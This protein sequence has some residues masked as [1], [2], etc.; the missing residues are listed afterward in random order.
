MSRVTHN[1]N[2]LE[3]RERVL[4]GLNEVRTLLQE[5]K[6]E[7]AFYCLRRISDLSQDDWGLQFAFG[8]HYFQVGAL[9]RAEWALKRSLNRNPKNSAALR[10]LSALLTQRGEDRLAEL[11]AKRASRVEPVIP[12]DHHVAGQPTVLRLRSTEKSYQGITWNAALNMNECGLR[13]GHFSTRALIDRERVNLYTADMLGDNLLQYGDLPRVDLIV[14]TVSCADLKAGP[15]QAVAKFL[16]R[17]AEIPAIN[18]PSMVAKTTRLE[19]AASLNE[20]KGVLFPRTR[21]M[22]ADG[23]PHLLSQKVV[24]AGFSFPVILR[25]SGTQTGNSVALA[26]NREELEEAISTFERGKEV[27]VIQYVDCLGPDGYH[28]KMRA[29]FVDG[30]FYPVANLTSDH[31]QIHSGD[32]YRVMDKLPHAQKAERSY[33]NNPWDYLGESHVRSLHKIA[34]RIDLDFFGIDF[35]I[36]KTGDLVIFEANAAMR[37]NFD[38]A[39]N[40]PYTRPFLQKISEAFMTMIEKRIALSHGRL[41]ARARS[42]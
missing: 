29:F 19:N 32:R 41:A 7:E 3:E 38:H 37:H 25:E 39:G 40:F 31:W 6:R 5:K 22:V 4:K 36:S 2:I 28:H 18:Q 15:L 21:K 27:Y 9:D 20:I 11:C 13:R 12:P 34:Q 8:V 16:A 42:G 23:A 35:A 24:E 33:L 30:T 1:T 17:H 26:T 14:N 10:Y